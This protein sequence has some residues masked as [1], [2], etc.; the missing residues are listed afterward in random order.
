MDQ[1]E[2]NRAKIAQSRMPTTAIIE[3]FDVEENVALSLQAGG[4][5]FDSPKV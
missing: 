4:L 3:P 5:G 2:V 1:L